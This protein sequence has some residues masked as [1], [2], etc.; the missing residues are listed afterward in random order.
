M[1]DKV[2]LEIIV[3]GQSTTVEANSNAQLHSVIGRALAA[4][5]NTGQPPENWELRSTAGDLLSLDAKIKD[6]GLT[7]GTRLFLN[8]KAGVG[9]AR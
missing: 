5:G 4:T 3:N 6:L 1:A 7:D 8:L 9:G 2:E